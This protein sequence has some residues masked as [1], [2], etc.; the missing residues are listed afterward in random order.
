[1]PHCDQFENNLIILASLCKYIERTKV[2][3]VKTVHI[4]VRL[5]NI[6]IMCHVKNKFRESADKKYCI[7]NRLKIDMVGVSRNANKFHF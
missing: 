4:Y 3:K 1:M 5:R 6:F 7:C 2:E